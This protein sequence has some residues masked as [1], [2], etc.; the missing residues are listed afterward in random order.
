M[1]EQG[2]LDILA[3]LGAAQAENAKAQ[4]LAQ[5]KTEAVMAEL[6]AAQARTEAAQAETT[7]VVAETSRRV[8]ETTKVVAET[9]RKL[10][11][12]GE[13]FAGFTTNQGD[14]AEA[15]FFNGLL[16]SP[17]IGGIHFDR[18]SSKLLVGT[19]AKKTEFDIVMVN[20]ASVAIIEVKVKPHENDLIQIQTQIEK[21]KTLFPEHKDFKLYGG[22]AGLAVPLNVQKKAKEL[23]FFV[24]EQQGKVV[25]SATEGMRAH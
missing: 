1:T 5:A 14:V 4:A 11:S 18:V 16:A 6:G 7:K 24:L 9:S 13:Q 3:G 20:G 21:Y 22:I 25:S 8:D 17:E 2:L 23:G 19:A 10:K 15:F 12:I